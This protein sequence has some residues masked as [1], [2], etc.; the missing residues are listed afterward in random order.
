MASKQKKATKQNDEAIVHGKRVHV[1]CK[2]KCS[3]VFRAQLVQ[4]KHVFTINVRPG[5]H[6]V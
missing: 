6:I 2:V 5:L 1:I 3:Q 4:S